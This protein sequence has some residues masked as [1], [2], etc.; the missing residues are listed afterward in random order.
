MPIESPI[1]V[2]G[3]AGRVG[4][5]GRNVVELLRH[6]GL[7]VRALVLREDER[8]EALRATGAEVVVGDLTRVPD[9]ARALAGCRRIYFGMSVSAPYLEATV[10]AAAVARERGDLEVFVNISQMTVSQMTMAKM[11]DSPQQRQHLLAEQ[12]LNWSGL[13]V[14]HVRPTVFLEN[15]F[16]LAWAAESIARDATIRL[17]F[18]AGRTSPVA[19]QDVAEV[20]AVILASPAAH[21]GK[22]NELTGPKSQDM[23]E[24][25]AEY[26][27]ALGRT[28]SYVDVPLEQWRDQ[29]LRKRK[30]PEH[31]REHLL[32]M[33]RLHAANRYDRIT[34]DVEELTGGPAMTVRDFVAQHVDLFA[35]NPGAHKDLKG[36]YG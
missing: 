26:S 12:I 33:A 29:E 8:A 34:H 5:V 9:V 6:R 31:V 35:P 23:I 32:T 3:A 28:I 16:F 7:A 17:P 18:G 30:L 2:T 1:L 20:I 25:A 10:I 27:R 21:I 13:P 19:V 15:P 22:V 36:R 14:V 11:T 4:G 24:V